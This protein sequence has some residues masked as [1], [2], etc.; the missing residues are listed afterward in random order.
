MATLS[1]T[2]LTLADWAK[3]LDPDGKTAMTVEILSQSNEILEDMLFKEGNLPTGEQVTIRTGLP[4]VYYRLMNQGVPKSKSATAQITENA[5]I[6]EAR[7]EV[8]QEVAELNGNVNA[9]RMDE[10]MAFV[11]AMSQQMATTLFYGSGANPEEFVGFANRYGDLSAANAQNILDAGGTGSDNSSV[12]LVGWGQRTVMGIFPKG[13]KAGLSHED[14]GIGDAFDSNND[15]FRAYMD[16][17]KWKNG[18]VVKDWRYAA[19]IANVDIS[20]LVGQTGTQA[21]TASTSIIKLMSRLIDRLPSMSGINPS[22]YVNRTVASH[23]RL[24]ALEKSSSAVTIEEGLNQF[25]DTIFTLRFLGIPV[26]L[27]DALTEAEAQ[28]T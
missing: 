13:S 8:D 1:S 28:V 3:R 7:S 27:V 24:I 23:L 4:T 11:E 18:L 15:R 10:A 21:L 12:W 20:D 17:W 22:F 19:R 5:A 2:V 9:F 16:H 6:L 26:R 25:G 14:L